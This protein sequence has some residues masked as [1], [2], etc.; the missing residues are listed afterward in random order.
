MDA[1]YAS[2]EIHDDPSLVGKPVV[3]GGASRRGVVAASS[4][5]ARKYGVRSAMSM[6]EALSRCPQAVVV[7]PRHSRYAEVS[8]KVFDVFHRFTPLVEGLSLDEAFLDVTG[9]LSLFGDGPTIAR[10][11]KDGIVDATGLKGSAGVAQSKFVAKIAS[12][13]QKPDGL[14]VVPADVATFLAPLP[15]ERMWG[16][17][18]KTAPKLHAQGLRTFADLQRC[19]PARLERLLGSWGLTIG[20]LAHGDD[21]RPVVPDRDAKSVGAEETYETDLVGEEEILEALIPHAERIAAR[22][23]RAKLAARTVTVKLKHHDH[24]SISRQ[25]TLVEHACDATTFVAAAKLLLPRFELSSSRFRLV[26]LSV[27]DLVGEGA[28]PSLFPDEARAKR[29][30]I[31]KTLLAIK[32]RFGDDAVRR[33]GGRKTR[34]DHDDPDAPRAKPP[35]SPG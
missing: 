29:T 4:Y 18:V 30:E 26:G 22:L 17:G 8:A 10:K 19:P 1:F 31:E 33:A 32:S 27:S 7:P 23:L 14:T 21:D 25:T 28:Q 35:R 12:D 13:L 24:R 3:V 20:R 34:I 11:I 5:E 2:V 16:V 15:I 6:V 9:S